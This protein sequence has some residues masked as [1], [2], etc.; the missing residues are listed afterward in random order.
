MCVALPLRNSTVGALK[1]PL[2]LEVYSPS[3]PFKIT[4]F[5]ELCIYNSLAFTF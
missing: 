3:T 1:S 5:L 2:R 4:Q